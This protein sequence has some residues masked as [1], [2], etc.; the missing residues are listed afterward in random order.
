MQFEN[1][2]ANLRKTNG[3]SQEQLASQ[4]DVS[5]Q[6]ISRWEAG[7]AFP[8][9]N[10]L[11]KL[12][13]LFDVSID[14]LL[15]DAC[16]QEDDRKIVK[17]I[18]KNNSKILNRIAL[19]LILTGV[20]GFCTLMILSSQIPAI[21]MKPLVISDE[22]QISSD[23]IETDQV[24]YVQKEVYSFFSFIDYYNLYVVIIIFMMII[25][26]GGILLI[27]DKRILNKI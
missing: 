12:G 2:L 15:N 1:K 5:R 3:L 6:A 27:Y 19:F 24:L 20:I 8:D 10:N 26:G 22:V 7:N 14:Y 11:K 9:A 18:C 4:L 13:E 17:D 23:Q 25:I 16:T 21:E